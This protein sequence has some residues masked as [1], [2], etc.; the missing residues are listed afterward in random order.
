MHE[1][2]TFET[3]IQ[4]LDRVESDLNEANSRLHSA[5]RRLR[6]MW[7]SVGALFLGGLILAASPSA[8]AQFGVTLAS[9]NARLIAVENKT[10]PLAYDSADKLLTVSGTNVMI[11]DGTGATS[12][13]SGLG[14]LQIGYNAIRTSGNVRTGSHNF[15]LGDQN[16]YGSYGGIITG[17][18]NSLSASY[19]GIIGGNSNVASG[20]YS[21]TLGGA[22]NLASGAFS[23]VSGGNQNRA[24]Q[25]Y[26]SVSGGIGNF[27]T[28]LYSTVSGGVSN[29][30]SGQNSTVS[31]GGGRSATGNPNWVGGGLFQGN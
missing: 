12:S 19:S 7:L 3:L 9:L 5:I 30:A 15:I 6:A 22:A 2:T 13:T 16:N 18:A 11:V 14:N 10:A 4:R 21:A 26:A 1:P 24:N 29:T 23:S 31:G 17:F 8:Q 25:G 27:A 20:N 28:G